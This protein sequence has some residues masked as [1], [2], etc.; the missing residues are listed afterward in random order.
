MLW[1]RR[2]VLIYAISLTS[3]QTTGDVVIPSSYKLPSSACLNDRRVG[4]MQK[5]QHG[6]DER[7][8]QVAL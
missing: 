2:E 5:R 1:L 7:V 3:R 6:Y 4:I 8:V